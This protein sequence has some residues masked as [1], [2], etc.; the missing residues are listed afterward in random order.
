M[1]DCL[2]FLHVSHVHLPRWKNVSW[3]IRSAWWPVKERLNEMQAIWNDSWHSLHEMNLPVFLQIWQ[4]G[5]RGLREDSLIEAV[6]SVHTDPAS[7]PTQTVTLKK[8]IDWQ[9]AGDKAGFVAALLWERC[10]ARSQMCGLWW[11]RHWWQ[12]SCRQRPPVELDPVH[13]IPK[14]NFG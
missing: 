12:G 6:F 10:D 14:T 8:T 1:T 3:W 5:R 4:S 2:A 13:R 7:E 9:T 11:H